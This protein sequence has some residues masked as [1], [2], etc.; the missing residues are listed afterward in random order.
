MFKWF[1]FIKCC[2]VKKIASARAE[3]RAF[4]P[5]TSGNAVSSTPPLPPVLSGLS[6]L[7]SLPFYQAD[8]CNFIIMMWRY[9]GFLE[10]K[11]SFW[12][13]LCSKK[14]KKLMASKALPS[15]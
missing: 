10:K 11:E 12:G 3:T 13:S 9:Q 4:Q 15:L 6:G 5:L 2:I 8:L 7:D 1:L 14:K